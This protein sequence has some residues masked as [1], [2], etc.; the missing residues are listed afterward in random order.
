MSGFLGLTYNEIRELK[1]H[2]FIYPTHGLNCSCMDIFIRKM[3]NYLTAELGNQGE[4]T[5]LE[6]V[7]WQATK[8]FHP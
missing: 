1:N 4:N 2:S 5:R 3:R 6:Y 8:D 7:T